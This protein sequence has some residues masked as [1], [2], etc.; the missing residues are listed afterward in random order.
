MTVICVFDTETTGLLPKGVPINK[1]TYSV[2]PHIVQMSWIMYDLDSNKI[3]K[4]I[5]HIV[6]CPVIIDNSHC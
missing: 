3:V 6:K 2:Y 5:D 4:T 1:N